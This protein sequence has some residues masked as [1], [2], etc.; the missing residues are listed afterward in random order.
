MRKKSTLIGLQSLIFSIL[1]LSSLLAWRAAE[2]QTPQRWEIGGGVGVSSY[3]GDLDKFLANVA[4][5]QVNPAF[6]LHLRRYVNNV[7]ALRGNVVGGR[8]AGDES[9][10]ST[11]EWRRERGVSFHS[12]LWEAKAG[13]E[14]YPVGQYVEHLIEDPLQPAPAYDAIRN[15]RVRT[16]GDTFILEARRRKFAPY[17]YL[18]TGAVYTKPQVDWNE[19]G[20]GGNSAIYY[21]ALKEDQDARYS[22]VNPLAAVGGGV[23]I[24]LSKKA[25]LGLEGIF[26]Y[27]FS[28]YIDG[29]SAVGNPGKKDWYFLGQVTFSWPL[30]NSD[31]DRDGL[32]DQ[33]DR[34][35]SW[36]GTALAAGCP[37]A[38]HDGV[39]DH[40][41]RC[42]D[43]AGPGGLSGCPDADADGVADLDDI[44]PQ[45][46][47]KGAPNGCPAT[48][49]P[50][51]NA[52]FK[53]IY[54]DAAAEQWL[55]TSQII[56]EEAAYFLQHNPTYSARIEGNADQPADAGS[57]KALSE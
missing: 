35:P 5:R 47:G 34:C 33:E 15:Y 44:C 55:P 24:P 42:P 28:D 14:F 50:Y 29:V 20:D 31:Q 4:Q 48:S 1:L 27:A 18:G 17:L 22:K 23:R 25:L 45:L 52:P 39:A 7:F 53:V 16:N 19:S 21:N 12:M 49:M 30:G 6:S 40:R 38:D 8:L 11:P 57:N 9:N 43:V 3:Q 10:F 26:Q 56:L 37:D 2:A 46:P 41:D 51:L 54:F 32:T 13:I 36:P